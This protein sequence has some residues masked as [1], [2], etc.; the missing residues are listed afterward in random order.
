MVLIQRNIKIGRFIHRIYV[1]INRTSNIDADAKAS[2]LLQ[3]DNLPHQ[4]ISAC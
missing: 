3:I 1:S 4:N 2:Q